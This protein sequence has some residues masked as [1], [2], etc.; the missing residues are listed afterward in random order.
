M[1]PE[2]DFNDVSFFFD[3][4]KEIQISLNK[5][6]LHLYNNHFPLI[7]SSEMVEISFFSKKS[8]FFSLDFVK[9]YQF[10]VS[11]FFEFLLKKSLYLKVDT[12]FFK[13]YSNFEQVEK[14]VNDFRGYKVR[15][16][17]FFHIS[18][19]IEII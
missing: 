9:F 2:D 8:K 11:N 1:S 5:P 3:N 14:I 13:K 15:F 4:L 18:E 6:Q 16:S 12:N 17:K 10:Y 19:M 7:L